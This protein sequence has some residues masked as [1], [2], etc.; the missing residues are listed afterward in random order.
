MVQ[1]QDDTLIIKAEEAGTALRQCAARYV[2]EWLPQVTA[3]DTATA[4]QK[5]LTKDYSWF[6]AQQRESA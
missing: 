1:C 3:G 4:L 2:E 6:S 5:V